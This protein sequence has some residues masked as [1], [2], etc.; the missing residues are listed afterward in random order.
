MVSPAGESLVGGAGMAGFNG[1]FRPPVAG[2][3]SRRRRDGGYASIILRSQM[4]LNP[5]GAVV[6]LPE[7]ESYPVHNF[8]RLQGTPDAG[9]DV[10]R[11]E[12]IVVPV[13]QPRTR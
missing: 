10:A 1:L 8:G 12:S 4:V 2:S 5:A 13:S 6:G 3:R 9:L 11:V 7:R